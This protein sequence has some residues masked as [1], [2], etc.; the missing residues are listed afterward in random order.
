VL[1][2]G[3]RN[4]AKAGT[5]QGGEVEH[6]VKTKKHIGYGAVPIVIGSWMFFCGISVGRGGRLVAI[7]HNIVIG[8]KP[9]EVGFLSVCTITHIM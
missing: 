5:E 7:L 3:M 4:A 6:S 9:V 2:S 8:H 1:L